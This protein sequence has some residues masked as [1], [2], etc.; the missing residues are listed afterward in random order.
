MSDARYDEWV[1]SALQVDPAYYGQ[2]GGAGQA[3]P[4]PES[5][6]IFEDIGDGLMR[7]GG[8]VVDGVKKVGETVVDGVKRVGEGIVEGAKTVGELVEKGV[9]A[10]TDEVIA[11]ASG[12]Y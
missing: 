7:A 11:L 2:S 6:N 3:P 5:E 8:A 9:K 10:V 1:K 12:N 4:M